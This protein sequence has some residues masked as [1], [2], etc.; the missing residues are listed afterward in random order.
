MAPFDGIRALEI[1]DSWLCRIE[2]L[3]DNWISYIHSWSR[4]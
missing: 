1:R 4:L 2:G 3:I